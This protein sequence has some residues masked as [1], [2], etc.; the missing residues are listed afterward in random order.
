LMDGSSNASAELPGVPER[1]ERAY[2]EIRK[3]A[4]AGHNG[5]TSTT[6]RPEQTC[7]NAASHRFAEANW[8]VL[9]CRTRGGE[10]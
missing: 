10:R 9:E 7:H 2:D 6:D 5:Q 8:Q 4:Q 1:C 3:I